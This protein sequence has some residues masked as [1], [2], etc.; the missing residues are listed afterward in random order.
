MVSSSSK[1]PHTNEETMDVEV[2]FEEECQGKSND[3]NTTPGV[4]SQSRKV[5]K[6]VVPRSGVWKHYTRTKDSRDK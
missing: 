2:K 4:S 6:V 5:K 1:I 3:A